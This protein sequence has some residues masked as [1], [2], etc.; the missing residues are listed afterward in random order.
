MNMQQRITTKL[1]AAFTP[2]SLEVV[3]DSHE[4]RGHGGYDEAG[5]H[6]TV[7][8]QAS[9]FDGLNRVAQQR[10]VNA[11][12]SEEFAD[13]LHALVIKTRSTGE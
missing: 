5:S 6:F 9:A 7:I 3:D 13:G 10:L 11:A 4:H 12:L 2:I 1:Q 8:I